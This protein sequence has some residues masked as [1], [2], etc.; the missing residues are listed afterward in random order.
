MSI[1]DKF[2]IDPHNFKIVNGKLNLFLKNKGID[3]L[4]LWNK[5]NEED[6]A[7]KAAA[8][9]KKVSQ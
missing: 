5:G 9:W 1:Q 3:A 8:H 6:F 7:A 2:P 4:A